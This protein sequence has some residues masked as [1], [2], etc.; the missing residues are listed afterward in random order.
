[1]YASA[2]NSGDLTVAQLRARDQEQIRRAIVDGQHEVLFL[3]RWQANRKYLLSRVPQIRSFDLGRY[4][5]GLERLI[6][7]HLGSRGYK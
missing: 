4:V 7:L 1:V 3:R 6:C 5:E 2:I